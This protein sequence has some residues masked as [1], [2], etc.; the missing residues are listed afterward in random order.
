MFGSCTWRSRA[1]YARSVQR[2]IPGNGPVKNPPSTAFESRSIAHN[3]LLGAR[4]SSAARAHDRGLLG[5]RVDDSDRIYFSTKENE[6]HWS[7]ALPARVSPH[8][9]LR[10]ERSERLEAWATSVVRVA[11]LRDATLGAAPQGKVPKPLGKDSTPSIARC[12][13]RR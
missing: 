1:G 6:R 11:T 5:N 2:P 13:W 10:S 9:M 7:A 8:L 4:H 3:H 12:W